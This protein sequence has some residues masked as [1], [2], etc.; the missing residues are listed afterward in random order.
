[1][2]LLSSFGWLRRTAVA[3][4]LVITAASS[5]VAQAQ[6]AAAVKTSSTRGLGTVLTDPS[7]DAVHVHQRHVG[8]SSCY[9]DCATAWPPLL[10]QSA[11]MLR[12]HARRCGNDAT[13]RRSH[14]GHV[15]RD[16]ALLLAERQESRRHYRSERWWSVV[17]R[18]SRRRPG[19]STVRSTGDFGD[20]M[21]DPHGMSLYM[22]T[23]DEPSVSNC[24]DACATAWPP[25]LTNSDPTGPDAW[26]RDW[27]DGARRRCTPGHLQRHAAVLLGQRPDTGRYHRPERRGCVVR[28]QSVLTAPFRTA[29]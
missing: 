15:Q 28:R 1:M 5:P 14:A 26:P 24:Y 22:Y 2:Q 6:S 20:I 11:P 12:R 29:L 25:L 10:T 13:H 27:D 21:V 23:K 18:Q 7:G 4:A 16:A 19:R 3:G 17:R 9:G 8:T